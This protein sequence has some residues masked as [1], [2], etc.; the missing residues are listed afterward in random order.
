MSQLY[1]DATC[2]PES[3]TPFS[4]DIP[5]PSSIVPPVLKI[6]LH[7]PSFISVSSPMLKK[8]L[9]VSPT[10]LRATTLQVSSIKTSAHDISS[11]LE[12]VKFSYD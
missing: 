2:L 7:I 12:V 11:A 6:P 10:S 9:A 8:N 5:I 3:I 4:M 1:Q